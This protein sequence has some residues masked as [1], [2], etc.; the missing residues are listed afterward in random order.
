[1]L[2]NAAFSSNNDLCAMPDQFVSNP[3]LPFILPKEK[4][5][6]TPLNAQGRFFHPDYPFELN[7][8]D[9]L[10]WKLLHKNPYAQQKKNDTWKTP[11]I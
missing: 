6:G 7:W 10:K 1:M 8:T 4:W 3:D 11:V 9:V 2:P 5:K